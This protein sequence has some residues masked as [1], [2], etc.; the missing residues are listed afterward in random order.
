MCINFANTDN[1]TAVLECMLEDEVDPAEDAAAEGDKDD[2]NNVDG[3]AGE[4]SKGQG[5]ENK[6]SFY[7]WFKG[8]FTINHKS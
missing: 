6:N 5:R 8:F 7:K 2:T 1:I 4:L 3:T